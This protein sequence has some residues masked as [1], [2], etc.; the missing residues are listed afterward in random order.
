MRIVFTATND[1]AIEACPAGIE[2]DAAGG[3]M[4]VGRGPENGWVIASTY[5]STRHAVIDHVDG[6]FRITDQGSSNG[7]RLNGARL[8]ELKPHGLTT[9][10]LVSF[11]DC[12]FEV[13]IDER[14]AAPLRDVQR[15][16]PA[17]EP[18]R[19]AAAEQPTDSR[20]GSTQRAKAPPPPRGGGIPD[21]WYRRPSGGALDDDAEDEPSTLVRSR[22]AS[23][24]GPKTADG[25]DRSHAPLLLEAFL[26][27]A[28]LDRHAVAP[29]RAELIM[30]TVGR[31][32]RL[33]VEGLSTQ[34][35]ERQKFRTNWKLGGRPALNSTNNN[36]IKVGMTSD[37][38]LA[39]GLLG[40]SGAYLQLDKA[41][42]ECFKIL[43]THQVAVHAG[44]RRA[45]VEAC[46][47]LD[48]TSIERDVDAGGRRAARASALWEAYRRRFEDI[49]GENS[50]GMVRVLG[51]AFQ[52][53]FAELER[54]GP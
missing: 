20:D 4:S 39:E 21:D 9:G 50:E 7:T 6:H 34:M 35:K 26:D 23:G 17:V 43:E 27:G 22:G 8:D 44:M 11:D 41:V 37:D 54:E 24:D 15:P 3:P 19:R 16:G 30:R 47:H 1:R 2:H 33:A 53:V 32:V 18:G 40:S 36:P 45:L 51:K 46:A 42:L 28:N 31:V 25:V 13:S 48:P 38:A 10:D 29:E 52:E 14:N 49:S 12:D 5:V